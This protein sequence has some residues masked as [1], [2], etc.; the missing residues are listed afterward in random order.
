MKLFFRKFIL[1]AAGTSTSVKFLF[2]FSGRRRS[3]KVL[4]TQIVEM[5]QTRRVISTRT[6]GG[7]KAPTKNVVGPVKSELPVPGKKRASVEDLDSKKADA[8]RPAF[9][10]ITNAVSFYHTLFERY[11][12]ENIFV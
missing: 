5:P 1:N 10:D 4:K 9:G 12:N 3:W 8:K 6:N 2:I 7:M 11:D